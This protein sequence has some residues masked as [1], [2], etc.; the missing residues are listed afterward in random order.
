MNISKELICL[1]ATVK[2]HSN[3]QNVK[4]LKESLRLEEIRQAVA[5]WEKYARKTHKD[6]ILLENSGYGEILQKDF[7]AQSFNVEV[8]C[9]P[10]SG[11]TPP[12]EISSGEFGMMQFL[13][14]IVKISQ[15]DFVWKAPGRN[16]CINARRVLSRGS[17]DIVASRIRT[18]QH[19]INTRMFGMTPA[20]WLKLTSNNCN[21]S[22]TSPNS[23]KLVY[24]SM[25]HLITQFVLDQESSGR[26][27]IDFPKVPR[28]TGIAASSGKVIDN[29]RRRI[30]VILTNPMRKLIVKLLL[31][32]V[33]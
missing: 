5:A 6:L 25:E 26:V 31:G 1:M 9:V 20:L 21:F 22:T 17:A 2:V 3:I 24:Q 4:H 28:F 29:R 16:F 10:E 7:Q 19:Y 27:Q 23:S 11:G 13:S 33:P 32:N 14:E 18:P 15:Y 30:L 8:F 12:V